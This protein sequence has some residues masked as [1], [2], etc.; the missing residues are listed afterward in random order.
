MNIQTEIKNSSFFHNLAISS[1]PQAV[2]DIAQLPPGED[3][4]DMYPWKIWQINSDQAMG[5]S[6]RPPLNFF[7]PP[8][9]ARELMEVYKFFSSEA[10]NKTG[11][12]KY[13]YGGEAKGGALG[14]ATGFSMMMSNAA[15]G[16]KNVVSHIDYGII[17]PTIERTH[18]FQLLFF[19]DPEYF[20]GDIKIIARGSSA[21]IAKEQ[22]AV[23]R[24]ELLQI[25]VSSPP[26][27]EIIGQVGLASMLKEIFKAGD[28]KDDEGYSPGLSHLNLLRE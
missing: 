28:F 5:S 2:V 11:V 24:N 20:V 8:S 25:V 22:A 13:A 26:V 7:V 9:I 15:R 18:E 4:T 17:K 1:G 14:T 6:V 3:I 16:I 19:N 23:R 10:D 12:P 27:L 21:L